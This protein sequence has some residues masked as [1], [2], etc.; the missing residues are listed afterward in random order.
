M[1]RISLV[2]PAVAALAIAG[3]A[4]TGRAAAVDPSDRITIPG[5]VVSSQP[6][7]LILRTDDHGHRML[8]DLGPATSL[9][10]GLRK[11]AHVT[12]TYHPLGPTG[13]AA[14]EVRLVEQGA[15][16]P[17]Q[18]AFKVVTGRTDDIRVGVR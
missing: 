15:F 14:D 7:K 11:G 1:K 9:P 16:V 5:T 13:Q 6:D 17:S 4:S 12:V 18:A 10:G 3:L 2:W 8:F